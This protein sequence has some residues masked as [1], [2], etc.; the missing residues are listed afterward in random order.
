MIIADFLDFAVLNFYDFCADR[1]H[2]PTFRVCAM[3][4]RLGHA[5]PTV[6][7]AQAQI[8]PSIRKHRELGFVRAPHR[9]TPFTPLA[10]RAN[11]DWLLMIACHHLVEVVAVERVE[12]P[13]N[14]FLFTCHLTALHCLGIYAAIMAQQV[15]AISSR[16]LVRS[17]RLRRRIDVNATV[18]N[19]PL[20]MSARSFA[21]PA[22]TSRLRCPSVISAMKTSRARGTP[23]GSAP[24]NRASFSQK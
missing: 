3:K 19:A 16:W 20:S 14:H 8:T 7:G 17:P 6:A 13:V 10:R 5:A 4:E 9:F 15:S 22:L 18:H 2:F 12:I 23:V 24:R 21:S 11:Q 1:L